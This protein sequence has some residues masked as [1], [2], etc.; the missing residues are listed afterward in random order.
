MSLPIHVVFF[1]LTG[2]SKGHT[3]GKGCCC[4]VGWGTTFS[5]LR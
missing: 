4:W 1:L 2:N 3:C 5:V